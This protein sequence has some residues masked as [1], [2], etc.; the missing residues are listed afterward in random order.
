[1]SEFKKNDIIKVEGY[2]EA[3]RFNVDSAVK[4]KVWVHDPMG[5]L[6]YRNLEDISFWETT[7]ID[8][9]IKP[10]PDQIK[11]TLLERRIVEVD[12]RIFKHMLDYDNCLNFIEVNPNKRIKLWK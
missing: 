12:N 3:C 9:Y 4:G 11:T 8:D 6:G 7:V 10:T 1:M 2:T 5:E